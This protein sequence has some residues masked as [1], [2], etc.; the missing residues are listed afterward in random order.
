MR[1]L[2]VAISCILLIAE[3]SSA[4]PLLQLAITPQPGST[5]PMSDLVAYWRLDEAAGAT[6][7]SQ[8]GS[9]DLTQTGTIA[10]AAAVLGNGARRASSD[11]G[12]YL[13][14]ATRVTS[15]AVSSLTYA[16]WGNPS[17]LTTNQTIIVG[18]EWGAAGNRGWQC[19]FVDVGGTDYFRV[20]LS[21]DGTATAKEYRYSTAATMTG[22]W[23]HV[24]FTFS[25]GTLKI[26]IN[27]SLVTHE[28]VTDNAITTIYN[29]TTTFGL[30]ARA[31]G[32]GSMAGYI[33]DASLWDVAL[34]D[35]QIAEMYAGGAGYDPTQ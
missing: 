32:T 18:S 7:V 24:A 10:Q 22:A 26:Y 20:V 13:A 14:A 4:N 28:A 5:L 2:L 1:A 23:Y 29:A 19:G 6:R 3:P 21:A 35:A 16:A 8:V 17:S 11:A 33:D 9:F 31:D 34:T 27:G 30:F 25:S 12:S 15:G